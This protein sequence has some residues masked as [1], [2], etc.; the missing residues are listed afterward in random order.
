MRCSLLLGLLAVVSSELRAEESVIYKRVDGRGLQLLIDKP[1]DWKATDKRP[2]IV[3]IHGG[4][5]VGGTPEQFRPQSEYFAS[6]GMVAVRVEYRLLAKK[7]SGPPMSC[8]QDAKS[9]MRYVRSHAAELGIDPNIIAAGGGSAGGHLAAFTSMVAGL[10]D[11]ADDLSVSPRAGA[12]VLYNP[13]FDNGPDEGWGQK[14]VGDRYPEFSPA[15]NISAD[16][17]PTIVL[18]GS[19]DKLIPVSVLERFSAGMK[20]AGVRCDAHVYEG[21]GHGFF[22]EDPYRTETLLKVDRF[23]ESLGYLTGPPTLTAPKE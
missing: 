18:L 23:L 6:R 12:L 16:D 2:A 15:H 11:P 5:W 19:Q 3:F 8:C 20:A 13:V 22:N 7:E 17:P 9:A 21:Q 4:G 14:R 10:D 1:T